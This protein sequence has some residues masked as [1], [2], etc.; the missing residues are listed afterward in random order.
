MGSALAAGLI[1]AALAGCQPAADETPAEEVGDTANGA[2]I[3]DITVTAAF[4]PVEGGVLAVDF[5]PD[6]NTPW[7]GLIVTAPRDGGLDFYNADGES[8]TRVT[9]SR[10]TSLAVAPNFALRGEALPLILGVDTQSG[11]VRGYVLLRSGPDAIE[12]PLS[13]IVLDGGA[14]ALCFVREGA[15]FVEIAVL[16]REAV[17]EVW[18]IS[19]NGGDLIGAERVRAIRLDG[20]ARTCASMDGALFVSGPTTSITRI[21]SGSGTGVQAGYNALSLAAG[22]IAGRPVLLASNGEDDTLRSFDA[23]TLQPLAPVRIIDGLSTPGIDRPGALAIS[24]V[25]FG[26]ASYQSGLIAAVDE[27]DGR[28]RVVARESFARDLTLATN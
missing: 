8:V 15:G 9:G 3:A 6:T 28:V 19:D 14:A 7:A 13:P 11:G 12:A 25:S 21:E 20:P 26:G 23:R 27:A 10:L 4:E 2:A 22:V 18:R 24:E 5:V 16:G 17:A 1:G